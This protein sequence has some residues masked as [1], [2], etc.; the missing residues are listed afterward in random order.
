MDRLTERA[1][2]DCYN[3][4]LQS[5]HITRFV[6]EIIYLQI[7]S[8][9]MTYQR[10]CLSMSQRYIKHRRVFHNH[11]ESSN[12]ASSPFRCSFNCN[13]E[14][15]MAII[16]RYDEW[17]ISDDRNDV[18]KSCT[19]THNQLA[20]VRRNYVGGKQCALGADNLVFTVRSRHTVVSLWL[21]GV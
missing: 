19:Y 11:L 6:R 15:M 16:V 9:L 18:S 13:N 4:W 7:S 10:R 20:T 17:L 14:Q 8:L 1:R 3:N 21:W 12:T 2:G 5:H